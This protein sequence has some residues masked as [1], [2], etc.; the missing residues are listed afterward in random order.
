MNHNIVGLTTYFDGLTRN[1]NLYYFLLTNN[2]NKTAAVAPFI[3]EALQKGLNPL[4][5]TMM[6]M[7]LISLPGM[8]T[9]QILGGS[10]PA[11][12][13]K[14]QIMI[15]L[16]IFTGVS[17]NLLTERTWINFMKITVLI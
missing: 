2:N 3:R 1:R 7:G 10:S 12:A 5:A 17:I 14:Y 11:I 13:I 15:M 16:A 9:G 6:V 4:I 8:M